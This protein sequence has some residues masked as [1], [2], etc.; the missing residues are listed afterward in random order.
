MGKRNKVFKFRYNCFSLDKN[1]VIFGQIFRMKDKL[2][3]FIFSLLIFSGTVKSQPLQKIYTF[4]GNGF[5][6]FDGDGSNASGAT[7]WG[8]RDVAFDGAGNVYISDFFNNRVRKVNSIGLI[9]T[10]AGNGIPGN[11]GNG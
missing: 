4:A 6:G 10:I 1:Y 5:A 7:L 8:P 9:T 2:C 11:T 3:L